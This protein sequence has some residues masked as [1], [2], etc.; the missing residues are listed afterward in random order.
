M[1]AKQKLDEALVMSIVCPQSRRELEIT[2]N[3][4]KG[5]KLVVTRQGKKTWL[6][7]YVINGTKRAMKLGNYPELRLAEVRLIAQAKNDLLTI[8]KDPQHE[9]DVQKAMP[10][11]NEFFTKTYYP[12]AQ[13]RKRSHSD[14][15][16]RFNNHLHNVI[17]HLPLNQV[18]ATNVMQ[19][20]DHAKDS[21]LSHA[22][23]NRIRALLSV[24]YS[25]AM[26]LGLV[27][28]NPVSRVK[29]Y[30]EVNKI[31][32]FLSQQELPRLMQVLNS[33]AE[34]G[35]DNLVIVAIVKVLL[36]T[37]MRKR[38]VMDMKW[39][40]VDL[41]SG[42]WKLENNKS[43]KPRLIRLA[44]ESLAEIRKMLPRQSE[45][46]FA[47]PQTGQAFNDIRKCYDK[48]MKAAGIPNMRIHDLRHN[49]ASMAVNKGL[50]LYVVQHLLGHASPQ[51]TQRYAHL[52][53]EVMLDAY[54]KVAEIVN[55]ASI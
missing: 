49:F 31:E 22:T 19:I 14:D 9:R 51:T 45:Y 47:N 13:K 26:D 1:N 30:K 40:D 10:T 2:D 36:L 32:R 17:G 43:G 20:L 8:G 28:K 29:K 16:S 41:S 4:V 37:G 3:V 52:N 48:I 55:Q 50:S 6:F 15:L 54:Q 38:E 12:Y 53:G 33:P 25:H 35:I 11:V 5:L 39:A 44:S 42:H 24:M 27:E 46:V 23:I 18:E 7:R 34:Y 21:E